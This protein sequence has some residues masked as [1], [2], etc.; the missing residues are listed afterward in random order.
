MQDKN[1]IQLTEEAQTEIAELII[2][3]KPTG[4]FFSSD[5]ILQD[6]FGDF[7]IPD[8][9]VHIA[10]FTFIGNLYISLG[11]KP[12]AIF[13]IALTMARA[14]GDRDKWTRWARDMGYENFH[15]PIEII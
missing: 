1:A 4:V 3:D 13:T 8:V 14:T 12:D 5:Q 6:K 9:T 7:Y 11:N 2:R 10:G 15:I